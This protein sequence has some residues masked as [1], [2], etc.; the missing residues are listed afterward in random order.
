MITRWKATLTGARTADRADAGLSG[1][2]M[3]PGANVVTT[4]AITIRADAADVWPWIAQLGQGRGGLYSYDRLENL[5]GCDI[6][7]AD[8]VHPEWQGIH[9]GDEICL[10]PGM[11]LTVALADPPRALVLRGTEIPMGWLGSPFGFT[12]A[13]TL[14]S[15]PDVGTRLV[16]RERYAYRCWWAGLL[17]RPTSLIS[18]VMSRRM[19]LGIRDRVEGRPRKDVIRAARRLTMGRVPRTSRCSS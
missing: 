1:D 17:V 16:V 18:A 11:A 5:L 2:A 7:S 6:H 12:W 9:T 3:L 4:R 10:A 13:F 8:R 15:G 14:R 19:L